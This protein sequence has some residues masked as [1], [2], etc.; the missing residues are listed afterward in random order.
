MLFLLHSGVDL[1]F[2]EL[3][4]D[5]PYSSGFVS[6][7]LLDHDTRETATAF[8]ENRSS[9]SQD[10]ERSGPQHKEEDCFCC[11]THVMPSPAFASLENAE[12]V[13]S[14]SMVHS[15]FIPSAPSD[16]PYHPPRLA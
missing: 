5:E 13:R 1:L 8:L 15:I 3:C 2:P 12:L 6:S 4:N 14:S 11:C 7:S 16:N 9:E 10:D